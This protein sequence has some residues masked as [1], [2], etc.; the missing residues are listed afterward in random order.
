MLNANLKRSDII[1]K[2]KALL[3]KYRIEG[4]PIS[5]AGFD[6]L[7]ITNEH[8]LIP[9][10]GNL[11]RAIV[12]DVRGDIHLS[13]SV[14]LSEKVV[15]LPTYVECLLIKEMFF[16]EDE[17]VVFGISRNLLM[18]M[19]FSNSFTMHMYKYDGTMPPVEKIMEIDHYKVDG[20][21]KITKGKVGG[22]QFVRILSNHYLDMDEIRS[23]KK[24]YAH[25]R[26]VAVFVIKDAVI[27]FS[28]PKSGITF[29]LQ[30]MK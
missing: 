18:N 23:I 20:D 8:Y 19:T 22:W 14:V 3:A 28:N 16:E 13:V 6:A 1:M 12:T 17:K 10:N 7:G 15:R 5:K 9:I 25:D 29:N 26:D 27:L 4:E 11:C 24:K 2:D 30:T 21:Y